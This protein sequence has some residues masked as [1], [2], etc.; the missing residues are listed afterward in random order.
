MLSEFIIALQD[1]AK[2]LKAA[3]EE[4]KTVFRVVSHLDADGICSAAIIS[5]ALDNLDAKFSLSVEKQLTEKIIV[6]LELEPYHFLIFTDFGSGQLELFSEHIKDKKIL[7][8]DH[9]AYD[10]SISIPDN[11]IF[12]NPHTFGIDGSK[13]ISGAGVVYMFS[14]LLDAKNKLSAHLAIIGAI[15]DAQ[16]AEGFSELNEAI[17]KDAVDSGKIELASGLKW[18][19]QETRSLIKL[20]TY[21]GEVNL[22]DLNGSES[23]A[24]Q[25]LSSIGIDPKIGDEWKRF[26]DLNEDEKSRL[27]SA[28]VM[29]NGNTNIIGR[30]Y[31]LKD[32][33]DS[34]QF[35]D[36]KEFSTLLN[37]CGRL[38]HASIGI[39]AC[40]DDPDSKMKA[41]AIL[42]EYRR[43]IVSSMRWFENNKNNA[44]IG[45]NFIILNAKDEIKSTLI[46]TMASIVANTQEVKDGTII[47]SLARD[48][49]DMTKVSIRIKGNY[50]D[51]DLMKVIRDILTSSPGEGGGHKNAAGAVIPTSSEE[52]FIKTAEKILKNITPT[53]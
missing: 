1:G 22:P 25:F 27:T 42:M 33:D 30:R 44:I 7:I 40:L 2:Q 18:F 5:K 23:K 9:H 45:E 46:G 28:I 6:E 31:L 37:A 15:G 35:R 4:N 26:N 53:Q 41:I 14:K 39:G 16:E 10:K 51:V 34:S 20:L 38:G 21:A 49:E 47:L 29:K 36:A 48:V 13:D 24:I 3:A 8:L 50:P 12:L 11:V 52:N 19:G 43:E 17:L 32:E